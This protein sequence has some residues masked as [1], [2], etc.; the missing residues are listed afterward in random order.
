MGSRQQVLTHAR[1]FLLQLSLTVLAAANLLLIAYQEFKASGLAAFAAFSSDPRN[2]TNNGWSQSFG[3]GVHVGYLGQLTSWLAVGAAYRSLTKMQDFAKYS[4]L[5]AGH[6][7][8]NIPA[9]YNFGV[10]VQAR[11]NGLLSAANV[12]RTLYSLDSERWPSNASESRDRH[13]G[14]F[15]RCG[16]RLA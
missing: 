10:A 2:L 12:Q 16:I 4:G 11:A 5:F 15:R 13:V 9:A 1:F 6:G 14:R 7:G 8:F 3:V